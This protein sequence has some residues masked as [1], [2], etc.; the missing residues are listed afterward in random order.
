[1]D[2]YGQMVIL[3]DEEGSTFVLTSFV[4][5]KYVLEEDPTRHTVFRVREAG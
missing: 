2:G 3:M 4:F 1:M 5:L